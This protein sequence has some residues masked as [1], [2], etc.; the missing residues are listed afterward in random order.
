VDEDG[1][2]EH[3]EEEQTQQV[4][5]EIEE[6]GDLA[7]NP[8]TDDELERQL[9]HELMQPTQ[10]IFGDV[11]TSNIISGGRSSRTRKPKIDRDYAAHLAMEPPSYLAA[12]AHGLYAEKP[13]KRRHRDDL[14]PLPKHWKDVQNHPFQQGWMDAMKKELNSLQEKQVYA[15]T[16]RPTDRSKQVLPLMWVFAYKFDQDGYLVKLK[17]RICVRGDLET[18]T[19]EEKRAATLAAKTAR[20]IFALI[21]A[22]DLD[23]RQRD[24]VTAFLNSRLEKETYTQMPEG[25]GKPGKC[26]RLLRAL[27]GLRIS[28]RLWQ[29]EAAGVLKKLGLRQVPEDP[30]V[31]VGDGIL[32]F[33]YVD[34]I[35]IASHHTARARAQQLER[36][37]EAHWELTDHGEAEWF[38]N[39]RIIRDRAQKKLWLCQDSYI[40]S[41]AARYNLT[42]RASVSTP[43]PMEELKIYDGVASPREIH[44]YQQKVGSAGYA[45]TITRVDAAKATAKL[46]QFLTNPGPQHQAAADRVIVYLNSTRFL[47]I[48]YS[49]VAEGMQSVQ[50]ASDAS[51]GDHPDRKSSAGFIYQVYG[52]AVD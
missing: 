25:F 11:D 4:L 42:E 32:V 12:F 30:C 29:Q 39:I 37:L 43:L 22:Y 47:A 16:D 19:A 31:F 17:A 21:A 14:P 9:Q 28:P 15:V 49:A 1:P 5:P 10:E 35:L 34:D 24:A 6:A 46:A 23:L 8:E 20:M 3:P 52:G 45:T 13:E 51:Y 50:L 33:F 2:Q 36:D 7:T 38:L 48:E 40:A 41:V 27:Y 44:V 26:W 18:I